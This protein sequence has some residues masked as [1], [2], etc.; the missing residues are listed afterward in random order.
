MINIPDVNFIR[1]SA[2]YFVLRIFLPNFTG[3]NYIVQ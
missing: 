2:R 1:R 3:Q